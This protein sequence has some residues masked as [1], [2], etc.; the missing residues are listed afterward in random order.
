MELLEAHGTAMARFDE[1]TGRIG[2]RDWAAP[3]PCTEWTVRDLLN[4]VVY[5]Q[6]WVPELLSGA[7]IAEIGD[8][9]DGDVLGDDPVGRWRVS[10]A[11]RAALSRPGALNRTV[12]LSSGTSPAPDYAWQLTLD[13]A[14]HGWDLARGIGTAAALPDG[15]A[16]R[17]YGIFA[18]QVNR[19]Q[20]AGIFDP[21]VPVGADARP[22]DR[23][24]GLLGR[25]P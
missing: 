2:E 4:H 3:T 12:H 13:L 1:L 18:G 8:R 22:P 15:L 5:E 19:W 10:A 9:F 23:L 6:L 21:P 24:L 14:V 16:E 20:G 25:Q 7:T 17:L 11:A